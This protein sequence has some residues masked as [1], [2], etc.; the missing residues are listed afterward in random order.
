MQWNKSSQSTRRIL[1]ILY[2]IGVLE[3]LT[4]IGQCFDNL[5]EF[6]PDLLWYDI[7]TNTRRIQLDPEQERIILT[8]DVLYVVRLVLVTNT[9]NGYERY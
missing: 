2:L 4:L 8:G 1:Y 6:L 7:S 9:N 5:Q 3:V